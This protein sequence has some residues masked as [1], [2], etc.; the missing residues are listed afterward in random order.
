MALCLNEEALAK[1]LAEFGN[2]LDLLKKAWR[3]FHDPV[4]AAIVQSQ[5]AF[6]GSGVTYE[7]GSGDYAEWLERID[8]E[9]SMHAGEIVGVF[10]GKI[11]KKTAGA[12]QVLVISYRPIVLGNMPEKEKDLYEK[13]AF[14]GQVP[15]RV[16]GS[17]K[18]GDYIIPTGSSDGTGRA[19]SPDKVTVD[20]L[21]KVVGVS[22]ADSDLED[23]KYVKII[24]GLQT[25]AYAKAFSDQQTELAALRAEV[26]SL[27]AH[28]Q[29]VAALEAKLDKVM[30]FIAADQPMVV[31]VITK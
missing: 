27:K 13:V 21:N 19:V 9:E 22:W 30:A 4:C 18:K 25:N 2:D 20:Q 8:H 23:A 10:G 12:D 14:M 17:V 11:S 5:I 28:A 15:V 3:M 31:P 26:T 7:S 24:V 6:E 16:I 29:Q 1:L